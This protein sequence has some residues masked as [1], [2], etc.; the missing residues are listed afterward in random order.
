MIIDDNPNNPNGVVDWTDAQYWANSFDFDG[1]GPYTPPLKITVLA[2][3]DGGIWDRFVQPCLGGADCINNCWVTPQYQ[4][5]DQAGVTVE[6]TCYSPDDTVAC[7]Q[8]GWSAG[9]E[10]HLRAVL[11]ALVPPA[12]CGEATP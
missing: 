1:T 5:F 9:I 4:V 7:I 6:D 8:C 2:D 11:D 3:T 12:W 10:T